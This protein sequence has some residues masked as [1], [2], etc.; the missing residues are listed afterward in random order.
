MATFFSMGREKLEAVSISHSVAKSFAEGTQHFEILLTRVRTFPLN[1]KIRNAM[2][3]DGFLKKRCATLTGVSKITVTFLTGEIK[4]LILNAPTL[5]RPY[6]AGSL[7]EENS[8]KEETPEQHADFGVPSR[9]AG[10]ISE[11]RKG[12]FSCLRTAIFTNYSRPDSI[13]FFQ[14]MRVRNSIFR[15]RP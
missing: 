5:P 10:I 1:R 11:Q 7:K 6:C 2:Q 12:V 13:R 14:L 15:N 4:I 9:H 8:C 3:G